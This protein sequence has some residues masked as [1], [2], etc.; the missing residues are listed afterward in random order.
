LADSPFLVPDR[1]RAPSA[2]RFK[3]PTMPPILLSQ[4]A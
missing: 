2:A 1:H 3:E 4:F